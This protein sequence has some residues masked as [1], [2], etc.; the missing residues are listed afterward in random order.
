MVTIATPSCRSTLAISPTFAPAIV[1][2]CP[3]PGV[4]AWAVWNSA[5]SVK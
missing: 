5:L 3:C 2:A 4:T 1:T